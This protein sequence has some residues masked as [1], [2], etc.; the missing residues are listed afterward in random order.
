MAELIWGKNTMGAFELIRLP[1]QEGG[2][3]LRL[4][5]WKRRP[6]ATIPLI[7]EQ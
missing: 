4:D 7:F 3:L 1:M 5:T 2:Q 6:T